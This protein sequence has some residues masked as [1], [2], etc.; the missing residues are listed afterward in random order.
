MK[1]RKAIDDEALHRECVDY[2][3]AEGRPDLAAEAGAASVD[4][5]FRMRGRHVLGTLREA[6]QRLRASVAAYK[7]S[8]R[9]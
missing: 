7:A 8:R 6:T 9:S 4:E 1:P 5:A 3:L 2:F